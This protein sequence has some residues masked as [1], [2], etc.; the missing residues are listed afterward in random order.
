MQPS[1]RAP[2]RRSA[3]P[4]RWAAPIK[5]VDDGRRRAAGRLAA[6]G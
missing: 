1:G 5:G 4:R 3:S 2:T 6:T